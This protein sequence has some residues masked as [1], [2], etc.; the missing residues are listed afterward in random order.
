MKLQNNTWGK[1]NKAPRRGERKLKVRSE[2][3][4]GRELRNEKFPFSYSWV[5]S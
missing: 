1:E 3:N 5:K 4:S 2:T